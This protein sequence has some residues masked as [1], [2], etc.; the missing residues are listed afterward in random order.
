[1]AE[2]VLQDRVS[3]RSRWMEKTYLLTD[4]VLLLL[5]L[6]ERWWY[7]VEVL[8]RKRKSSNANIVR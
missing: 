8:K 2:L 1:M 6:E 3:E 5:R 7:W 4:R